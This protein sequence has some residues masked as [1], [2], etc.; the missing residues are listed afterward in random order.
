MSLSK[1][2]KLL[3]PLILFAITVLALPTLSFAHGGVDD[4]GPAQTELDNTGNSTSPT[5]K[6][7]VGGVAVV[8]IGLVVWRF[9]IKK[10]Q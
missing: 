6:Y 8:A 7:A 9:F 5:V 2:T 10:G 1:K 4:E 3:L